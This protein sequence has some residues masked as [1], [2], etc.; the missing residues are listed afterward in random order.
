MAEDAI[1]NSSATDK[2]ALRKRLRAERQ[3]LPAPARMAAAEAIVG[4]A[5]NLAPLSGPGYIGGYWASGGELPLHVMQM[6]LRDGQVWCLPVVQP[7]NTLKF[8]AWLPGDSLVSNRYG[9]PEP[10]LAESSLIEPRDMTVVLVPLL[11][12]TAAGARL[13]QGGGYYDRSFEFRRHGA[14]PPPWLVGVG[15]AC[16]QLDALATDDWDTHLDAVLTERELLVCR[17]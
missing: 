15:Y 7:D 17:P 16:Q 1:L 2:T 14:A 12:F 13:G 5:A 6:R 4:H 3:A 9:I 10:D 8:G 11:G